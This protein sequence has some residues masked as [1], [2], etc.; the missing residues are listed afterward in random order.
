[1]EEEGPERM[2]KRVIGN[3]VFHKSLNGFARPFLGEIKRWTGKKDVIVTF[4]F[5]FIA[6]FQEIGTVPWRSCE[7]NVKFGK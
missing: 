5:A 6:R 2:R 1:V 4:C 3:R 7:R